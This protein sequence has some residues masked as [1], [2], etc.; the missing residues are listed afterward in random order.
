[1]LRGFRPCVLGEPIGSGFICKRT[2]TAMRYVST[3]SL[4]SDPPPSWCA[5]RP[6]ATTDTPSAIRTPPPTHV[7]H[8]SMASGE[9]NPGEA[10]A[11]LSGWL[12]ANPKCPIKL[13]RAVSVPT[14]AVARSRIVARPSPVVNPTSRSASNPR[15]GDPP[16]GSAARWQRIPANRASQRMRARQC[17]AT[18]ATT[19][20]RLEDGVEFVVPRG[21]QCRR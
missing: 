9:E 16:H 5:W 1:M 7:V 11:E 4:S 8:V 17:S 6:I 10:P 19:T 20:P 14:L 21:S 12:R 2:P 3:P 15:A 18:P 13:Q